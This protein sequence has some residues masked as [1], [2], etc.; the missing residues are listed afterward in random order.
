M[1]QVVLLH[2]LRATGPAGEVATGLQ[3]EGFAVPW[4][5]EGG[6]MLSD[7]AV[8][9]SA[10]CTIVLWTKDAG[11]SKWVWESAVA[12][13]ARGRLIEVLLEHVQS[14]FDCGAR[15]IDFTNRDDKAAMRQAWKE[16]IGRVEDMTGAPTGQL[17]LRKQ[18]EPV[19][20]IGVLGIVA[21]TTLAVAGPGLQPSSDA[22]LA[23]QDYRNVSTEVTALGGP[24][25]S[26]VNL[27]TA[28]FEEETLTPV[29]VRRFETIPL[30]T[31]RVAGE[32]KIAG[33]D[34][35]AREDQTKG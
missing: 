18:L 13:Q 32:E 11:T 24:V 17:P 28:R 30:E 1:R 25:E 20:T 12:A 7:Q 5:N 3:G 9:A 23:E 14:P 10:P 4:G 2:T 6:G 26:P 35:R 19:G 21:A 27:V 31:L 33:A 22:F 34:A 8:D 15:P 29:K 16:L